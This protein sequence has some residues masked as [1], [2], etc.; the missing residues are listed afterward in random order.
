MHFLVSQE[1]LDSTLEIEEERYNLWV[2][3]E[4]VVWGLSDWANGTKFAQEVSEQMILDGY[5]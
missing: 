5:D 4:Y 3:S 1:P 2:T